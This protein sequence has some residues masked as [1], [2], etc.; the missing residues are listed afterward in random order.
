MAVKI[1]AC[2]ITKNEE[3]TL[4]RSLN[5]LKGQ[6]DELIVVDTG[7]TD[8]TLAVAKTYGAQ[9]YHH[10]WTDDFA[11]ARNVALEKATGDWIIFLDAD[12]YFAEESAAVIRK[13]IAGAQGDAITVTIIN[14]QEDSG[15]EFSR[16]LVLRMWKNKLA[17]R[18]V[19]RIH[20]H[21]R[22]NGKNIDNIECFANLLLYHTGY[23][24]EKMKQKSERNLK[25]LMAELEAGRA[26]PL[27]DRYFAECCYVLEDCELA[28]YYAK[29]AIDHEPPTV[30]SKYEIYH[31]ARLAMR[32]LKKSLSEQRE[33]LEHI[34][35]RAMPP[36]GEQAPLRDEIMWN[37][38]Q[39]WAWELGAMRAYLAASDILARDFAWEVDDIAN[40]VANFQEKT[41]AEARVYLK[42]KTEN[43]IRYFFQAML[44][45][46]PD[47]IHDLWWNH[48]L[49][50]EFL[51]IIKNYH[52]L[53]TDLAE[54]NW[55]AYE[56]G[57]SYITKADRE[58][59]LRYAWLA[60]KFSYTHQLQ[61]AGTLFSLEQYDL[62][63]MLYQDI[64]AADI[65]DM[66]KY[67]HDVAICLYNLRHPETENA[68][69][70]AADY[71]ENTD[72]SS[73]K[74]WLQ[75]A[76]KV[77]ETKDGEPV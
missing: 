25:L 71:K 72:I 58:V 39:Q 5:S 2:Y 47:E 33:M 73:Y 21:V 7:S 61:A 32:K 3:H 63:M 45:L 1:S 51:C 29:Q 44:L 75:E 31:I 40:T 6:V 74:S 23:S 70:K 52:G 49:P 17:R 55:E 26:T 30:D 38:L 27:F 48:V 56:K 19:G 50:N 57:L 65:A 42:R 28:F 69:A 8:N 68:L 35:L 77:Q 16:S 4:A 53:K 36:E 34:E 24:E 15:K 67:W 13:T 12:E 20:E 37:F 41:L 43:N 60:K 59:L 54:E 14:I 46:K 10:K 18:Y 66:A 9:I 22:E 76:G 11:A 62:A 64:P